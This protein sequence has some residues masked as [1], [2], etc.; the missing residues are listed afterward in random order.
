MRLWPDLSLPSPESGQSFPFQRRSAERER[1]EVSPERYLAQL[2]EACE[3]LWFRRK[4]LGFGYVAG[5]LST[6]PPRHDNDGDTWVTQWGWEWVPCFLRASIRKT[7]SGSAT[8]T[9]VPQYAAP[10]IDACKSRRRLLRSYKHYDRIAL[11]HAA[12]QWVG[13]GVPSEHLPQSPVERVGGEG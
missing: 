12:V 9:M 11:A 2:Q 10:F 3:S 4:N 5:A 6:H 13:R 7:G 8:P 1:R